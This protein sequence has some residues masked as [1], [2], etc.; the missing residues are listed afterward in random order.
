MTRA[1]SS[2]AAATI[3]LALAGCSTHRKTCALAGAAIGAIE[4]GGSVTYLV[5][6]N[7]CGPRCVEHKIARGES[8]HES[9]QHHVNRTDDALLY[10]ALPA[11][12]VGA[13][14]GA[15]VGWERCKDR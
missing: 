3:A 14:I 8:V 6:S 15:L 13:A 4:L 11:A 9:V 2:L 1:G 5:M 10:G 12:A 7:D